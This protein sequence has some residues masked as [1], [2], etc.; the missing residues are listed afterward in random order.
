[1]LVW[2]LDSK[3]TLLLVTICTLVESINRMPITGGWIGDGG[4]I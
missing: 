2:Y 4:E 3:F 1:M